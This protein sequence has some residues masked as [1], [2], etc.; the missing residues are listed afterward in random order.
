MIL[1]DSNFSKIMIECNCCSEIISISKWEYDTFPK[2]YFIDIYVSAFYTEQDGF[3]S[4]LKNR[5]KAAW[6]LLTKGTY[7]LQEIILSEEDFKDLKG[8]IIRYK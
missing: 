5:I 2:E 1:T 7:S 6:F 3:F 4:K 8:M